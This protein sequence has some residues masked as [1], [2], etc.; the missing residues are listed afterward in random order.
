MEAVLRR[1]FFVV[2]VQK[3]RIAILIEDEKLEKRLKKYLKETQIEY[4]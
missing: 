4:V 1:L 2:N 3:E